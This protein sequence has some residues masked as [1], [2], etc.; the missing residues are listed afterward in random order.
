MKVSSLLNKTQQQ[1]QAGYGADDVQNML[2][3]LTR[4]QKALDGFLGV[5]NGV[6]KKIDAGKKDFGPYESKVSELIGIH[7][8]FV[9]DQKNLEKFK[10]K[11]MKGLVGYLKSDG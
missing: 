9:T 8:S 2:M 11:V 4:A 7:R 10:N 5:L 3:D 6:A 1:R